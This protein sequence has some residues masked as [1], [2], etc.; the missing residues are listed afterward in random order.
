M[1]HSKIP[2]I[3]AIPFSTQFGWLH[4]QEN[5]VKLQFWRFLDRAVN[6]KNRFFSTYCI[7]T[8]AVQNGRNPL[9]G[10]KWRSSL[11]TE[12]LGFQRWIRPLQSARPV[13][14]L[15]TS[16]GSSTGNQLN[17]S[18]KL[19]KEVKS[20]WEDA[21]STQPGFTA[22][23]ATWT[24]PRPPGLWLKQNFIVLF[25]L[26]EYNNKTYIFKNSNSQLLNRIFFLQETY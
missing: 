4:R 9:K 3:I 25:L 10:I 26:Y 16:S 5:V 6:Q 7:S 21:A 20:I 23:N 8:W 22:R 11:K 13:R 15:R 18:Q 2:L 17:L 19:H 12:K 24:F 14:L 1:S